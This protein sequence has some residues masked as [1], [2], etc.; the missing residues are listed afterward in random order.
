MDMA[1]VYT[2][3]LIQ[4]ETRVGNFLSWKWVMLRFSA[5][6]LRLRDAATFLNGSAPE[7]LVQG[8]QR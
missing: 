6:D 3:T 4:N 8:W 7:A 2:H 5:A 1:N